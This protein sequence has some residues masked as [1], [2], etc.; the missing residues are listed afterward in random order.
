MHVTFATDDVY[1]PLT[2]VA[3]HSVCEAVPVTTELHITILADRLDGTSRTNLTRTVRRHPGVVLDF[4]D[5]ADLME[6]FERLPIDRRLVRT[7]TR[8]VWSSLFLGAVLPGGLRRTLYLDSDVIVRG[9]P[10][11][12]WQLDL[13]GNVIGAVLSEFR[14][15][16]G[17]ERGVR[18]HQELG[19]PAD[20]G[21]FNAG[22]L[23]VDLAR[24]RRD[25]ITGRCQ[26]ILRDFHHR[27]L[28]YDQEVLN[29]AL[30]G[31]WLPLPG[32]WNAMSY[33]KTP[34]ECQ[35]PLED[36]LEHAVIRH[37]AGRDK[38]WNH[39]RPVPHRDEFDRLAARIGVV[40]GRSWL[41]ATAGVEGR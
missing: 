14:H 37:F 34:E 1:A 5:V 13:G 3:M 23:L 16:L 7:H 30:A 35:P 27:V 33:W 21:Y 11:E 2:A 8:T 25:D 24:W 41:T 17:M 39:D 15:T 36:Y 20:L 4:I 28:Q 32:V 6:P 22:V 10:S 29:A 26:E 12:L 19:L 38:P 40:D 18:Y 31:R 9:D